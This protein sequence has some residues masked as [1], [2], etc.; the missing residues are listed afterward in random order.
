MILIFFKAQDKIG[1]GFD[2][3]TSVYGSNVFSRIPKEELEE[4]IAQYKKFIELKDNIN[5]IEFEKF[6]T[7]LED[8]I[9]KGNKCIQISHFETHYEVIML[10]WSSGFNTRIAVKNVLNFFDNNGEQKEQFLRESNDFVEQI[11][12]VLLQE[13]EKIDFENLRKLNYEY[14]IL[15][16][17]LGRDSGVEIEPNLA[18]FILDFFMLKSSEILLGVCPGAGGY[19]DIAFLVKKG[20]KK[21]VIEKMVEYD[22]S[23]NWRD[24]AVKEGFEVSQ[25]FG[26]GFDEVEEDVKKVVFEFR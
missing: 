9:Q 24:V 6:N 16:K 1:S 12:N 21:E 10:N 14:R 20:K 23:S 5:Y 7:M 3:T 4:L 11:N 22:F 19:D 8:M 15:M 26:I 2:I 25:F 17:K 13:E 18:S